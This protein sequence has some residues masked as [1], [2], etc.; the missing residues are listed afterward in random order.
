VWPFSKPLRAPSLVSVVTRAILLGSSSMEARQIEK[1]DLVIECPLSDYDL[2]ALERFD[3]I[4]EQ[5]YR[6]AASCLDAWP[7]RPPGPA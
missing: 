7:G 2:F 3:E 6:T 5:G 4:V 1:A